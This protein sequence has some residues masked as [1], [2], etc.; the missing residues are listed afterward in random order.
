MFYAGASLVTAVIAAL[1]GLQAAGAFARPA[2][3]LNTSKPGAVVLVPGYGGDTRALT[4]LANRIRELGRIAVVVRLPGN[5]TGD[6]QA[7][8]AVLNGYVNREVQLLDAPVDVIGYSRGSGISRTA[9]RTR[10]AG[11]SRWDRRCTAPASP[12][13]ETPP[14]PPPARSRASSSCPAARCWRS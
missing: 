13:R 11:L 9:G 6:L 10:P 5:G 12:R 7:Q 4:V 1:G 2:A 14:T 3:G 8:A